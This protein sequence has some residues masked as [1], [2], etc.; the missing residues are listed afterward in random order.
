M[1]R[2]ALN[3]LALFGSAGTLVCCALPALLVALGMGATVAGLVSALPQLVWLSEKKDFLFAGCAL[4]LGLSGW[5]QWRARSLTCPADR[6]LAA[7]CQDARGWSLWV[8]WI[9]VGLFL[10]GL[11]VAYILPWILF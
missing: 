10:V 2:K 8:Y 4:M 7:A 9:S 6:K 1:Y 11:T 5:L 3:T